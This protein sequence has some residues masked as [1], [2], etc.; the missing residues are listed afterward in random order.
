MMRRVILVF[1]DE[2][3]ELHFD[4]EPFGDPWGG[5][6]SSGNEPTVGA[7]DPSGQQEG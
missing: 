7:A 4:S 6:D 2:E 3:Y 1:Q 5:P